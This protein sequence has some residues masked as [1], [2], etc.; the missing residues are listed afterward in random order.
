M[1]RRIALAAAAAILLMQL[2]AV[3]GLAGR[4]LH[5]DE[6]EYLHA[7]WLMAAGKTI[8][9]DFF[10]DHP[11]HLGLFLHAVL[12]GGDLRAVDVHAWAIRARI[13]TGALGT[14][15]VAAVMLFAWRM[16]RALSAPLVAAATLLA[17]SQIWARGLADIRAEAPTLALFWWGIVLLTWSAER[18]RAQAWRAGAG[19]GL[20][21]FATVWNPKWPVECALAGGYFLWYLWKTRRLES[22]VPALLLAAVA[23][24]PLFTVTTP[25]DYLFFNF[26]LKAEVVDEFTANPW[27]VS[28]FEKA[29]VWSTASPQHRW[30]WIV[31]A[32]LLGAIGV[33]VRR[34]AEPRLAW[35][36]LALC[37]ASLLEFRFVYPYPYLWAQY[38]VMIAT[39]A[40]LAYALVAALLPERVQLLVL[41]AATIWAIVPLQRKAFSSDTPSRYWATQRAMQM[42]LGPHDTVFISPPRHPVAAFDA[43]YY[44]YNFRESA[45]S[46]IRAA[47]RHPGFLPPIG[48]GDLPPCHLQAR[49]I[50][51]GDWIP[52]L[53]GVCR[54]V[55]R[56]HARLNPT[57]ALAIF[58]TGGAPRT[59]PWHE[60]TRGLWTDLCRRQEV[61]LR[62][63]QLNITP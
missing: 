25:R 59:E 16:T 61:F 54:C 5:Y 17:S 53:D 7:S 47:P 15:A 18:S 4:P 62:G 55:E 13:L 36:A 28:F 22:L 39:S 23:L 33:R 43:S 19:I 48:F 31:A 58:D 12:P 34:L 14:L 41:A 30:W 63:G 8:Y 27:I 29:P 20:M 52:F 3:I 60:R 32:V 24:L 26:Q 42:S 46:A 49:Y 56:N 40:A 50:E 9:R 11:P 51:V 45:P 35:I 38:L 6:N 21:F 44:W 57:P 1:S 10:E 37:A 2:L